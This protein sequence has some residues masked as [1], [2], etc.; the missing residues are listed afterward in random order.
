MSSSKSEEEGFY[1]RRSSSQRSHS[2]TASSLPGSD[3]DEPARR[4][5]YN[6]PLAS[7]QTPSASTCEYP[8]PDEPVVPAAEMSQPPGAGTGPPWRDVLQLWL[9]W[10]AAHIGLT[11]RMFDFEHNSA[12]MEDLLDQVEQLRHEAVRRS[13]QLIA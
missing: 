9:R 2:L 5:D 6:V 1:R 11:S 13:E 7:C 8:L 3:I 12:M 10:N 4:R